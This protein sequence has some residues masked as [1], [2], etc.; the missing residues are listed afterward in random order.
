MV[1]VSSGLVTCCLLKHVI[2]GKIKGWILVKNRRGGRRKQLLA[3]VRETR[4]YC[5][6]KEAAVDRTLW[7]TSFGKGCG[8][9]RLTTE[10]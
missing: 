4:G 9:V 5:K 1:F 6:L 7:R 8:L 10:P 2:D 3:D